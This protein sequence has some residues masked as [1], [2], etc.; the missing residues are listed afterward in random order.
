MAICFICKTKGSY[1]STNILNK[2]NKRIRNRN[3][4]AKEIEEKDI[5]NYE[6]SEEEIENGELQKFDKKSDLV[7]C[8]IA[9]CNKFYHLNCLKDFSLFKFID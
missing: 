7:K 1:Y 4:N 5:E 6:M 3:N 9:N 2:A 8:S